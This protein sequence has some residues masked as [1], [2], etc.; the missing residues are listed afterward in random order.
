MPSSYFLSDGFLG[1]DCFVTAA[2]PWGWWK[3]GD[4]SGTGFDLMSEQEIQKPFYLSGCGG[5]VFIFIGGRVRLSVSVMVR[6]G[7]ILF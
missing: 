2:V 6:F 3:V 5:H 1:C 7:F 4:D